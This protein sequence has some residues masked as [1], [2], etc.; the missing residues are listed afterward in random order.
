MSNVHLV[1]ERKASDNKYLH[2]DFHVTADIGISYVGEHYGDAGVREYLQAYA[3]SFYS[4]LASR[5]RTEGLSA[6]SDYLSG[7]F[8]REERQSYIQTEL[9][10]DALRVKIEKCPAIEAMR[11]L[12]HTPSVW[13]S[14]TT[15][16]VYSALAEMAEVTFELVSYCEDTGAAEY[17]FR[18]KRF[19]R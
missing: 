14:E 7:I 16:T 19:E 3:H 6:L 5:I 11:A 12:G 10:A 15:K 8:E 9:S 4:K 17:I 1:M 18:K 13:Y 2:R